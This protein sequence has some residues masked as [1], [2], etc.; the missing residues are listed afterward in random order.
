MLKTYIIMVDNDQGNRQAQSLAL[1]INK[2]NLMLE[3]F[4][5]EATVPATLSSHTAASPRLSGYKWNWPMH[6]SENGIDMASGLFKTA[7]AAQDQQKV[8]ACAVSHALLWEKCARMDEPIMILESDALF[9][10]HFNYDD[11]KDSKWGAL[12]LNDPRGTTRKASIFYQKAV[13]NKSPGV[14][15]APKVDSAGEPLQA[16]GLAGNSAYV[17]RPFAARQLLDAIDMYGLWPND[18]LICQEMFPWLRITQPFYTRV[19]G[20]ASATKG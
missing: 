9:T 13:D 6:S 7:Y 8:I 4:P 17:L 16:Q 14:Y 15:N 20:G 1:S 2:H 10:R 5:V 18:A 19:Q 3:C 11:V 12:G